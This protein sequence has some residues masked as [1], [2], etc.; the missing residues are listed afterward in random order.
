MRARDARK[1][2]TSPP[3]ILLYCT[4]AHY[5]TRLRNKR[6]IPVCVA[7]PRSSCD[8][9]TSVREATAAAGVRRRGGS[10]M[11]ALTADEVGHFHAFGWVTLRDA[12]SLGP[13]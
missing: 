7:I 2:S 5:A 8:A 6:Y 13:L 4:P 10:E 12:N 9:D 11:P 1:K 3:R